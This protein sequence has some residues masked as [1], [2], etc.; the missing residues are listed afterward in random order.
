MLL[1]VGHGSEPALPLAVLEID[2]D[3]NEVGL[4]VRAQPSVG[5]QCVQRAREVERSV[6]VGVGRRV[7]V[8]HLWFG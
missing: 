3:L 6:T 4:E 7:G 5:D 8:A 1:P 2:I